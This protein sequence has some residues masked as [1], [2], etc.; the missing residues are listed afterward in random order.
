MIKSAAGDLYQAF[1]GTKS[2]IGPVRVELEKVH[3]KMDGVTYQIQEDGALMVECLALFNTGS[4]G[5]AINKQFATI[6]GAATNDQKEI[7]PANCE[8]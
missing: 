4:D 2:I 1:K 6:H 7:E 5:T 8:L 3:Q